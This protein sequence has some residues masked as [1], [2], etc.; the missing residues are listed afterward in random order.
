MITGLSLLVTVG[1]TLFTSLTD[2]ILSP[3]ILFALPGLGVS[4]LVV[5]YGRARI[6]LFSGPLLGMEVDAHGEGTVTLAAEGGNLK[7][8]V[9]RYT[10]DFG[11]LVALAD[12]VIGHAGSGSI[13]TTLRS[14]KPLL[15]VP[16]TSLMDNHQA[17]LAEALEQ[18]G[19]LS[20]SSIEDLS[21]T[22][23]VWL[24]RIAAGERDKPFP[25]VDRTKFR[26]VMDEVA[27][28]S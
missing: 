27:G 18:Q 11:R 5:Q 8:T 16:N 24:K 26:R 23:P 10:N 21:V 19:Y 25:D 28:F 4:T 14:A 15:V 7:V 6:P 17:E 13:L 2:L 9:L 1:S 3:D 12:C 20:V 22:L